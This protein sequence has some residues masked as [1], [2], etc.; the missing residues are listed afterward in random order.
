MEDSVNPGCFMNKKLCIASV[1]SENNSAFQWGLK[2]H[3]PKN[4]ESKSEEFI[5][6]H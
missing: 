2:S 1:G 5:V 6:L 3:F 4:N